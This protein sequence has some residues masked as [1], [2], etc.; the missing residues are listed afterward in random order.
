VLSLPL[1]RAS[2]P[3]YAW[4]ARAIFSLCLLVGWQGFSVSS[5][6]RSSVPVSQ[7]EHPPVFRYKTRG[8]RTDPGDLHCIPLVLWEE[9]PFARYLARSLIV[10]EKWGGASPRPRDCEWPLPARAERQGGGLGSRDGTLEIDV[11]CLSRGFQLNHFVAASPA[12]V[13]VTAAWC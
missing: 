13:T 2:S 8:I 5:G 4:T 7:A 11:S 10:L 1:D 12:R 3:V 6:P 9:P